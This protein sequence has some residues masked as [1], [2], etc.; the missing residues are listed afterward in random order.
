MKRTLALILALVMALSLCA[1]S[2][3]NNDASN[4]ESSSLT[5]EQ[6]LVVD[7]VSSEIQSE[8]FAAWQ[9]FYK[10]DSGSD[11][12]AP[13]VTAVLHYEIPDFE[14]EEMDCYLIDISTDVRHTNADGNSY[15]DSHY[16]LFVSSDGKTVIDSISTDVPG[17][18][19]D[20]STP[21]GRAEYLL[22]LFWCKAE[23]QP[24]NGFLNDSETIT[25]WSADELAIINSNL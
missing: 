25:E 23:G 6:Q 12:K 13:E 8:K 11:P 10:E 15:T 24:F 3:K 14:G 1:C 20:V 22:W 5:A 18:D 21:E 2:G 9:A 17:F 16:E 19:G 4:G 7:A